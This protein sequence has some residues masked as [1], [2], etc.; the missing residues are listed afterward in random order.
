MSH[1]VIVGL[2]DSDLSA[3][4]LPF[5]RTVARLWGGPMV[6]VHAMVYSG[7]PGSSAVEAGV[8]GLAE[9]LRTDGIDAEAVL[10]AAPPAQAIV[11]VARERAAELIVM[12][13]HQRRGLNR[14]VHGSVTEAVLQ[15]TATPL[16]VV[17]AHALP[18]VEET[19]RVLVPLDGSAAGEAALDL[20]KGWAARRPIEVL[21]LRV[22]PNPRVLVGWDPALV[23]PPIDE[24]VM[25]AEVRQ[26]QAYLEERAQALSVAGVQARCQV[27]E[28]AEPVARVILDTARS[29]HVEGIALGTHG[30]GGVARLVLGSESEDVLEQSLVPV[31]LVRSQA[32]VPSNLTDGVLITTV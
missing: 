13:S 12:A 16:L 32:E 7:G 21:L 17:P 10:R 27:I 23:V 20:L 26:A 1:T 30:K 15:N 22:V 2:D 28:T 4:A 19:V 11:E 25:R 24:D 14:W 18:S 8:T 9:A 29:E 31:L 5:A 3:R 6:L